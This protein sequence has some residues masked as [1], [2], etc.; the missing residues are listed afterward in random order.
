MINTDPLV[1]L[2]STSFE[3]FFFF[4]FKWKRKIK[5]LLNFFSAQNQMYFHK[6]SILKKTQASNSYSYSLTKFG[7]QEKI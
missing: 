4:I 1:G 7:S 2:I 5:R 3:S 6:I